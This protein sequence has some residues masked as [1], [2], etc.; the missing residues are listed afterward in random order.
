MWSCFFLSL[1]WIVIILLLFCFVFF[2]C[3]VCGIPVPRPGIQPAPP[4][5]GG[6]V[7]TTG[8]P[9]KSQVEGF[10]NT[11]PKEA[12]CHWAFSIYSMRLLVCPGKRKREHRSTEQEIPPRSACLPDSCGTCASV[13]LLQEGPEATVP[14]PS[15]DICVGSGIPAWSTDLL[16]RSSEGEGGG[17]C[18]PAPGHLLERRMLQPLWSVWGPCRHSEVVAS[19]GTLPRGI[20]PSPGHCHCS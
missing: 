8:P 7:S 9:G 12:D 3:E 19:S 20:L 5:L 15:T 14:R 16:A 4:A 18:I 6:D 17:S 2:S 11:N 10:W 13:D 1:Y